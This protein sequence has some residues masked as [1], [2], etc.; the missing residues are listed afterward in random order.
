MNEAKVQL[1]AEELQ[2]VQNG[3]WV[4]TK[5]TIIQKVYDLFGK[6][7]EEIKLVLPTVYL[8][9]AVLLAPPKISRG[10]NYKGLPYVMLDYPRF[11]SRDDVFA[12]RCFFWW[13]NYFSV[14]LHLK[15]MYKEMFMPVI[16]KNISGLAEN[17]FCICIAADEW[18]HELD[19]AHYLPL[20]G[21]DNKQF[22]SIGTQQSFL[23]LSAKINLHQ[24]N[25]SEML[26][27]KLC[28]C[29]LEAVRG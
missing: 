17:N 26:L 12:I 10:E 15:G 25:E 7:S 21:L 23:K 14:T 9:A 18:E 19:Q 22:D 27:L 4:L 6:L 11:F 20:P 5:N 8:P 2:L 13:G 3:D 1:S 29:L 16:Q 28:G 24:W